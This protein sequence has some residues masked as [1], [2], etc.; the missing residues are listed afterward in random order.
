ML[1]FGRTLIY[2]VEVEIEIEIVS[3]AK[4]AQPIEM[5]F[6]P[7]C[8]FERNDLSHIASTCGSDA[9]F[10]QIT[11]TTCEL[12]CVTWASQSIYCFSVCYL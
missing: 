8:P 7:V 4:T 11:L 10:C 12:V 6:A 2:V 1:A 9:A 3:P 5:P